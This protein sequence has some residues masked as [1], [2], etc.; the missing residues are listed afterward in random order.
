MMVSWKEMPVTSEVY[1]PEHRHLLPKTAIRR[2]RLLPDDAFGEVLVKTGNRVSLR[3]VVARGVAPAPYALIDA[4]RYFGLKDPDKLFDLLEVRIG[5]LVDEGDVLAGESG[6]RGKRLHAP[7]TGQVIEITQGQIVLQETMP[8]IELEAGLNGGVVSVRKGRGVVMEAYGA[9]LQ[10]MWGNN[11]RAIGTIRFEPSGGIESLYTDMIETNYRGIV[12]VTRRPLKRSSFEV[13]EDRA[14]SGVIAPGME[15][16]MIGEA[17]DS[18]SAILLTEGFGSQ[19]MSN[20]VSQFLE[21]M[22]GRQATVD[23]VLPAALETRHPEVIINVPLQPG[24][25]PPPPQ[26]GTVLQVGREVR[27]TSG[28]SAGM[29][30]QIL[31]LP[32][33]PVL[34]DNGLYVPCAQVEL[35]TGEK[36]HVPLANIEVSGS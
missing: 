8:A 25:R 23:A 3:D 33:E 20:T 1:Y 12:I 30:G 4:A 32:K 18:I 22:V 31:S 24:E 17:M 35:V 10:G 26:L 16:D 27:L 2:E 29:I 7:I 15:P 14:F 36:V 19:R 11:R 21:E 9:V 13:I 6:R 34:L 28:E 5:E